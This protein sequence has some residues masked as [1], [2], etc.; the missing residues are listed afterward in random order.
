V[1]RASEQA[2]TSN[3]DVPGDSSGVASDADLLI[4]GYDGARFHDPTALVGVESGH[5]PWEY[6]SG[7]YTKQPPVDLVGCRIQAVEGGRAMS[8]GWSNYGPGAPTLS[9]EGAGA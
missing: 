3:S 4:L 9:L 7:H 5:G 8:H 1:V 6:G 2:L